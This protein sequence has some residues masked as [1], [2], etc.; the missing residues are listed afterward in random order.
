VNPLASRLAGEGAAG[1][2]AAPPGAGGAASCRNM[3]DRAAAA[4]R[5][6]AIG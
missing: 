2:V 1:A 3:A 4:E 6:N 5:G